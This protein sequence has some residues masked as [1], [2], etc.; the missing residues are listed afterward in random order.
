MV[1]LPLFDSKSQTAKPMDSSGFFP[2]AKQKNGVE[3]LISRDCT[4][5]S[6]SLQEVFLY[7]DGLG[8]C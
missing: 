7:K 1:V 6:G 8:Y 5:F 3:I 2:K 4:S